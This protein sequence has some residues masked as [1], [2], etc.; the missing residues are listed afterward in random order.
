MQEQQNETNSTTVNKDMVIGRNPVMELLK[1]GRPVDKILVAQGEVRGS[2]GKIIATARRQGIPIKDTNVQKM[3]AMCNGA[4][5]QGV[6]AFAAACAYAELDDVFA[7]AESREEPVLVLIADELEDPHN[8]GAILRTA[9]CCGAHGVI[10]PK[11]RSVGLTSTVFKTSAGAAE[12]VPVVR[13]ANLVSTI[14]ELKRRGVWIYAADMDGT[15][16]CQQ[17]YSGPV[18]LIVGAEGQG[19]SRLVKEKCDFTVALPMQ[20][21]ISS[22]NASV[23]ASVVLYEIARQRLHIKAK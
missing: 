5:H 17:D 22:R 6:I 19:V 2:I 23:A 13:V 8:L 10:I 14:E 21:K 3:D 7:L 18:G 12:Y 16:W 15:P 4:S 1:S 11:R 9:E 20:G